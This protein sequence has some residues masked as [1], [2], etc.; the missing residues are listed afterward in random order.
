MV[1][2]VEFINHVY[3]PMAVIS[4]R[5]RKLKRSFP[6]SKIHADP[7]SCSPRIGRFVILDLQ[8]PDELL[9]RLKIESRVQRVS[10]EALVIRYLYKDLI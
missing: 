8:L 1:L 4:K 10:V 2:P 5:K 3:A 6:T 7:D 9:Q